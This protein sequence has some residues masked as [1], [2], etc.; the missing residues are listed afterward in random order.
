MELIVKLAATSLSHNLV[1]PT[2]NSIF[3][4]ISYIR[5][6]Y[7]DD[8]KI[9]QLMKEIKGMDLEIKLELLHAIVDKRIGE[10]D[11]IK[12]IYLEKL[13]ELLKEIENILTTIQ[14]AISAHRMRWFHH[15]R[16]LTFEGEIEELRRLNS[17]L[18]KRIELGNSF[19][20]I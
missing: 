10:L 3:G 11:P 4:I 16:I 18:E 17:I 14:A 5:N 7:P 1:I 13:E 8:V 15:W 20:I 19:R 2:I 12:H 9:L 6:G